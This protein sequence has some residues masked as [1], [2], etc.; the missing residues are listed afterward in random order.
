MVIAL[1]YFSL[2]EANT[3]E[4]M[5]ILQGLDY[6]KSTGKDLIPPKLVPP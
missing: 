2:K 6:R 4:L 3:E 5:K 1:E